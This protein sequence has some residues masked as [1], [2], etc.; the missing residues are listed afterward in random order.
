MR[1]R[2]RGSPERIIEDAAQQQAVGRRWSGDELFDDAARA[3]L[4]SM[5]RSERR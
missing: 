5:P 3:L 2:P 1:H 4:R